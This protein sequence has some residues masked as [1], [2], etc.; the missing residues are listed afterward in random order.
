MPL[1][2]RDVFKVMFFVHVDEFQS[3]S[4]DAFASLLSEARKFATHFSL[5]NQY[6]EQLSDQVRAAVLGNAGT[7]MVF[8]VSAEDAR[9][10]APEFHPLP[11][12][13]LL[14]QSPHSAWLRR[15]D[16]GHRAVFVS[17]RLFGS[18]H[19]A[20]TVLA[21][22]RKSASRCNHP[23]HLHDHA[24]W[25]PGNRVRAL[26]PNW[27]ERVADVQFCSMTDWSPGRWSD[28]CEGLN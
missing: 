22:N 2:V 23:R 16:S 24:V 3:F 19:G 12:H 9:L 27:V 21:Q 10:L 8:R 15:S 11:A 13:E 28:F 1:I 6:T 7:L 14:D 20:T 17:P 5:A 26:L 4:T 25:S 18:R